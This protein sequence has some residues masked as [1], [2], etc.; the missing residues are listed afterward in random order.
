MSTGRRD[1]T[2]SIARSHIIYSRYNS[3]LVESANKNV[4]W[5]SFS[6]WGTRNYR[7]SRSAALL[8]HICDFSLIFFVLISFIIHQS[9]KLASS[10][11]NL[12][13]ERFPLQTRSGSQPFLILI[14]IR[15]LARPPLRLMKHEYW[16]SRLDS[17]SAAMSV[18]GMV[19]SLNLS[20][21]NKG[22]V[23][24]AR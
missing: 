3:K 20:E 21:I 8:I 15:M 18:F 17:P 14:I 24:R 23:W 5:D 9:F 22:I 6:S 11:V 10:H 2:S 7:F 12:G 13:P 19:E 16:N 4:K 1:S